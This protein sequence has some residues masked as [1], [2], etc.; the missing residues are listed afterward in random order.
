VRLEHVPYLNCSRL[1]RIRKGATAFLAFLI[2]C[3]SIHPVSA[4]PGRTARATLLKDRE[5]SEALLKGV[6]EAKST[7]LL[8]CYLFKMTGYTD[9]L[10][11][12]IAEALITAHNRGVAVTVILERS[13]DAD[14]PLNGENRKTASFMKRK[15]IKV[16]FDSLR[17]RT[18]LKTIV[19]DDRFVYIGSHNLTQS[20]LKYNKE[21]SVLVDSPEMASELKSYLN[22]LAR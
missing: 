19:I 21:V 13:G 14:D 5:Y 20:A 11:D 18:H 10:P 17:T 1:T 2:L 8:S 22:G 4:A 7:I 3:F 15:G 12:R 16:A 9:S 6:R